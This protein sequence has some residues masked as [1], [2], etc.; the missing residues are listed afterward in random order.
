MKCYDMIHSKTNSV[1]KSN[2]GKKTAILSEQCLSNAI[3]SQFVR[4]LT[5]PI[6]T[7]KCFPVIYCIV[8]THWI[9]TVILCIIREKYTCVP[10]PA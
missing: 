2:I 4:V 5:A 9:D 7:A 1:C 8:H 6:I 10:S 3:I